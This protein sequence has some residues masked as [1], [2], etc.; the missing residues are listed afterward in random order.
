MVE[1]LKTLA[2]AAALCAGAS[3]V[4]MAQT[5]TCPV[6]YIYMNGI[7]QPTAS[8]AGVV[9]AA[10]DTAGAIAAG[11]IGAVTGA[12]PPPPAYYG[13]SYPPAY[14]SSYAPAYGSSYAPAYGSSYAPAYGSSY[15][16]D[17]SS[18]YAGYG[19]TYPAPHQPGTAC[20]YGY[21]QSSGGCFPK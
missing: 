3:G 8:P 20:S 19:N 18:G 17:Y 4:A 6:G 9:G 12:T 11:T 15:P 14:G 2:I 16:P 10:V 21:Y 7:C 1:K 5:Y 13:S